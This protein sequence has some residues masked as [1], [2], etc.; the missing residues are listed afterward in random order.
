M[1]DSHMAAAMQGLTDRES[2]VFVAEMNEKRKERM[3][4]ALLCFFLGGFGAHHLY[5]RS[6]VLAVL[7]FCCFILTVIVSFAVF[8]PV[9]LFQA[10]L[11]VEAV[12]LLAGFRVD[13]YNRRV[14][15]RISAR[16]KSMRPA[17]AGNGKPV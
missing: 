9:F 12:L 3:I 10:W 1:A 16:L 5:L 2:S 13:S 8:F 6:V 7:Y 4:A 11:F 17:D 14:A 15:Y